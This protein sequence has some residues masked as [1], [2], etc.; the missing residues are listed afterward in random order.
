MAKWNIDSVL[1]Y[2]NENSECILLSEIYTT[3][4]ENLEFKCKCGNNFSTTFDKFKNRN[5]KQCTDC[6]NAIMRKKQSLT[7]DEVIAYIRE[8]SNS[9]LLSKEYV[10]TK[11]KLL[12]KCS[13]GETFEKSFEKFKS[14]S[15][16][17]KEC[18]YNEISKSQTFTLDYVS[19]YI[20]SK[21]C[22][23]NS[24]I[25]TSSYDI[26][27]IECKCGNS[28]STDFNSFKNSNQIR[29]RKCTN[30][31]SKGEIL[32]EEYLINN[33]IKFDKQFKFEELK[34]EN[35]KHYLKFDFA[36][37]KEELILI[38]FDGLQ[39]EAPVDFYGGIEA[40]DKLKYNDN[41]K[42]EF[43][44]DNNIKLIRIKYKDINNI[45]SILDELL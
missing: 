3:S 11:S 13:C 37:F 30:Q 16:T 42:N 32:I 4:K 35:K 41:L 15:K 20:L 9:E 40:Y 27:D 22:K 14:K 10:N 29:C 44:K 19:D 12:F 6:G 25:Y 24:K 39:H 23:L 43:C 45:N 31:E 33:N 36:V 34:A 21:S 17:C 26:L 38:E 1:N 2:V 28:Y 5:K 18:S 7:L 8:N